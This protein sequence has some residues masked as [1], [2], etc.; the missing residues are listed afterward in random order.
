MVPTLPKPGK[1]G[2]PQF[3]WCKRWGTGQKSKGT[4]I[5][6]QPDR[7]AH[8]PMQFVSVAFTAAILLRF[9]C[10]V[11]RSDLL[12]VFAICVPSSCWLRLMFSLKLKTSDKTITTW[13]TARHA[14]TRLTGLNP[15]P[16]PTQDAK[17]E[18]NDPWP[19][20]N[21]RGYDQ[22]MSTSRGL[23]AFISS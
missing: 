10:L 5:R 4:R 17:V 18:K 8:A 7:R 22:S 12:M 9:A 6:A 13:A 21:P 2:H 19:E 16:L 20:S 23:T 15:N 3:W 1:D 14:D 11:D